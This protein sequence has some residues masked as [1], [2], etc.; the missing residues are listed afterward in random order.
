LVRS[1]DAQGRPRGGE[2]IALD[3]VGAGIGDTVLVNK[4]GGSARMVL[5][6]DK[7]PVAAL[8]LGV[9]DGFH[10]EG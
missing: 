10:V 9:V 3:T 5:K 8:I 7:I 4:E 6:N 1:L 2:S